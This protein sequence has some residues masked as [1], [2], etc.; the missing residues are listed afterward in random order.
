MKVS[1]MCICVSLLLCLEA[2]SQDTTQK[3]S[4]FSISGTMGITYE[5][6]GLNL[7]PAGSGIYSARRP[8]NQLRFQF[9]P[10]M[11]WGKNF[12]L[13]FNINIAAIPTNFAGPY[14]GFVSGGSGQTL[15]Q[16]LTNPMNNIGINPKYK[17]AELQLGTQYL[18]YS[19]LSTGDIGIFGVGIDLK[20]KDFIIKFFTGISQQGVN[21]SPIPL[22][23]GVPGAYKRAHWMLQLGKEKEDVY[24]VAFTFAKGKDKISSVTNPPITA[25]PQEGFNLSFLL[26]KYFKND[27]TF[28]TEVAGTFF[29]R[30]LNMPLAPLLNNSFKPFIEGRTSTGKDW[31]AI[32][33]I[34]KKSKNFDIG[35]ATKYIGA[36]FQTTGY[37]FLQPDRWENTLNTRFNAWKDKIN[38]V[39]SVGTRINN[40]SNT[41]LKTDQFIANVNWFTQF[42]EKFSTNINYNNFGFTSA[43]GF[44]PFGIKNVSNDLGITSTYT[45]SNTKRM[46]I[47]TLSYN[48]SKYDERDVNTGT[49]TSNNT[50]TVLLTYIPTYF[51][52]T[53]SPDFS[54]MYFNN[55]IDLPYI[56]NTLITLSS[57]VTAS[58]AKK[59]MQLRG[60]LQYTIGNLNSFSSNKNLVASCN[61][62]YKLSKK[63]TWNVLLSTNYYRYGNELAPPTSLD[64]A[65]YLESN[66]RTGL[67]F[68]F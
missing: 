33:S 59:K 19:E 13:P 64:G 23:N 6:Y 9:Q 56:K 38:V 8:W 14:S 34:N 15:G 4:L 12:T 29:T 24:K 40:V 22:P 43:S 60:Q 21:Y 16:W 67:Q 17:W 45:W 2:F 20:P 7:K 25:L 39:A 3:K 27:W 54:V 36:G 50:H 63:L 37:P 32:A 57:S 49:I 68:K 5:G 35:Y 66:Y 52:S 11:K 55:K 46:N 1:I 31:A 26:D 58:A 18:K 28:K 61:M 47:L 51:N 65:N 30:D 41:S 53:I 62:G 42:S 10:T 44:N 48:L